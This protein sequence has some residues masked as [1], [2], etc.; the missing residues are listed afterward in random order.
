MLS[1][2]NKIGKTSFGK[3]LLVKKERLEEIQK[4]DKNDFGYSCAI[5]MAKFEKELRAQKKE[6]FA[7]QSTSKIKFPAI[8]DIDRII[9]SINGFWFRKSL[10]DLIVTERGKREIII[11]PQSFPL[12]VVSDIEKENFIFITGYIEYKT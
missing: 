3:I 6:L 4:L 11:Y 2:S 9:I 5:G 1:I 8:E 7:I 10:I 12:L